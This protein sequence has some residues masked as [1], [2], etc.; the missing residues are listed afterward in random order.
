[1][2]SL[3]IRGTV[4]HAGRAAPW[5]LRLG[6]CV[7]LVVLGILVVA[8]L[9]PDLPPRVAQAVPWGAPPQTIPLDR[10]SQVVAPHVAQGAFARVAALYRQALAQHPT[11]VTLIL[12]LAHLAAVQHQP[13]EAERLSQHAVALTARLTPPPRPTAAAPTAP[14]PF[15]DAMVA[16]RLAVIFATLAPSLPAQRA[17]LWLYQQQFDAVAAY[18]DQL[19]HTQNGLAAGQTLQGRLALARQQVPEAITAFQHALRAAPDSAAAHYGLGVAY[20]QQQQVQL[21]THA[22]ATAHTLAPAVLELAHALAHLHMEARA[23][24]QA[25]AVGHRL[26]AAQPQH[27]TAHRIVGQAWLA[28]GEPTNGL[29]ALQAMTAQAPHEARSY[30]DL[31]IG[32]RQYQQES[33]ALQAFERALTLDP[34][35]REALRQLVDMA[36]VKGEMAQ[37]RRRVLRHLQVA[38]DHPEAYT[39]LSRILFAEDE[40]CRGTPTKHALRKQQRA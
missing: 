10:L 34:L 26:L 24:T 3:G 13:A 9:W 36:L 5:W 33:A 16:Y 20:L 23:F 28:L 32:Y 25:L 40:R 38:P 27:P 39:L 22:W 8:R 30:Y 6:S 4:S 12:R 7:G 1:M 37:A 21:A 14:P 2:R 35:G 31:G 11:E 15:A 19:L 29:A 17:E 18:A